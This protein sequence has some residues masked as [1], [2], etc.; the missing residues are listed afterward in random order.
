[1]KKFLSK[2]GKG[3]HKLKNI[4]VKIFLIAILTV[5]M[6]I[7]MNPFFLKAGRETLVYTFENGVQQP[8]G[9]DNAH[10]SYSYY[11]ISKMG[12]H[13]A[14]CMDYDVKNPPN[15]TGL[16]YLRNVNSNK[17]VA[18]LMN[19]YPN[20]SAAQLGLSNNQEA[21]LAT[22]MAVWQV[23]TGTNETKGLSFNVDKVQPNVRYSASY[24][25]LYK[26]SARVAKQLVN[27][28]YN[29]GTFKLDGSRASV[30]YE[31]RNDEISIGP[32]VPMVSG[33]SSLKNV[34]VS[35]ANAPAGMRIIDKNWNNKTT[36]NV[37]ENIYLA[38]NRFTPPATVTL[39]A[40]GVANKYVGVVYGR[41]SWQ[42]F[43]FL[44]TEQQNI[45]GAVNTT[46]EE[47]KGTVIVLKKDQ[48]KKP[49]VGAEF[50]LT[51]SN[52]KQ[53]KTQKTDANG[54]IAFNNLNVGNYTLTE[55]SIPDGYIIQQ[56]T[57]PVNVKRKQTSTVNATNT[58]VKGVL[59]ITKLEKKSKLPI[60]GAVF[61]V[62]D[63][64][65]NVVDKI[66]TDASGIGTSK[67][68]PKGT[69]TYKEISVP[70]G[71]IMDT[72]TREFS[73][74]ETVNAIRETIYNEKI[75]GQL[76]LIK[77]GNDGER[78][79]EGA[80]FEIYDKDKKVV[81]KL[82]TD[83]DGK[84]ISEELG[85][86]TYTYKETKAPYGYEI[87]TKEY[88][89]TIETQN[90]ILEQS[91]VNEKIYGKIKITKVDE[92]DKPIAGVKFKILDENNK[93]VTTVKTDESG[94]A[95]VENLPVGKYKYKEVD[96]PYLYVL[97]EKEYE[98]EI[99][100]EK[101]EDEFKVVN[102]RAKGV[103]KIIK[104]DKDDNKIP[105]PNAKFNVIDKS[106]NDI[107]DAIITDENGV[108][109]TKA[110]PTGEYMYQEVEVPDDYILESKSFDIKIKKNNETVEK[111]V[112]NEHKKLPVTGGFLS[113]NGIIIVI[114]SAVGI[115]GYLLFKI[116]KNRKDN[117]N[118]PEG[119]EYI[120]TD[121]NPN[122]ENDNVTNNENTDIK[123]EEYNQNDNVDVSTN[124]PESIENTISENN[125]QEEVNTQTE[126]NTQNENNSND[127]TITENNTI[128]EEQEDKLNVDLNKSEIEE[129]TINEENVQEDINK[130]IEEKTQS[131]NNSNEEIVIDLNTEEKNQNDN[132]N[133][134]LKNSELQDE[135]KEQESNVEENNII[136]PEDEMLDLTPNYKNKDGDN[137]E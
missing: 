134:D 50:T 116:I 137:N 74:T 67:E 18:V 64:D 38:V 98:F 45:S 106:T 12:G 30:N 22:Q 111:K 131:E 47:S 31:G 72:E 80:E 35:L 79:L 1:M 40:N 76:R 27:T 55:T 75:V 84:A 130:E 19:G 71:Y 2:V 96:T 46:W 89:F 37:N 119:N 133:I 120:P 92:N 4:K 118:P 107:V 97:D 42:N 57:Y 65:G 125:D 126:D 24:D 103:L 23:L 99:T 26:N 66:T 63:K 104:I 33:Y 49:I 60:A 13:I 115:I 100:S 52:G 86:G 59:Q 117:P 7:D 112:T 61:E 41:G 105:I 16:Q 122:P 93:E 113:T 36:F 102:Q 95:I 70:D 6:L 62:Y 17:L 20:K 85:K 28:N 25:S 94:I 128:E 69:Y 123:P 58:K 14:Y 54:Y 78:P 81:G 109:R 68:L 43:V 82:V 127:D 56:S 88:S 124:D 83:K 101:R 110:L 91:L 135:N 8:F 5:V 44:D 114:V 39:R 53:V 73:V 29:P 77:I 10:N 21:Y 121:D 129:G 108:A 90:Q 136:E 48:D 132:S 51:D 87:D 15:G 34:N 9:F 32:F 3:Y 11:S